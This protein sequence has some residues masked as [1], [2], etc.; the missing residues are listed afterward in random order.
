MVGGGGTEENWERLRFFTGYRGVDTPTSSLHHF[1]KINDVVAGCDFSLAGQR[2][3]KI[4]YVYPSSTLKIQAKSGKK[5]KKMASW[6]P[7]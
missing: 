6:L 5:K 3:N 4:Y 7:F 1:A 2:L